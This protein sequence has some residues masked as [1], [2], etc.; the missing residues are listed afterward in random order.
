MKFIIKELANK[1]STHIEDKGGSIKVNAD[2]TND[3]LKNNDADFLV[4]IVD[5]DGNEVIGGSVLIKNK[6][7]V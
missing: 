1:L 4:N 7:N 5:K 6:E 3:W 2:W